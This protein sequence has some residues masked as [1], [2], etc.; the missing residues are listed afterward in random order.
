MASLPPPSTTTEPTSDTTSANAT[1]SSD[2][3]SKQEEQVDTQ[4]PAP[5]SV[6]E[7]FFGLPSH[8]SLPFPTTLPIADLPQE[9]ELKQREVQVLKERTRRLESLTSQV[10]E[11]ED[12]ETTLFEV[13]TELVEEDPSLTASP[14]SPYTTALESLNSYNATK[15]KTRK[16][17]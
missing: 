6:I 9:L 8:C 4:P 11:A 14:F 1:S 3:E 10:I 16:R 12:P 2:I 5:V 7:I 15:K 13:L 17:K